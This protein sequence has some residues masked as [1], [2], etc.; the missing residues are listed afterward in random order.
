MADR[1]I[2]GSNA[3]S[4]T[5]SAAALSTTGAAPR[6][7]TSSGISTTTTSTTS[8]SSLSSLRANLVNLSVREGKHDSPTAS[9]SQRLFDSLASNFLTNS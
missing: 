9:V 5:G 6:S 3:Y 7:S 1:K 8:S 4:P 2:S